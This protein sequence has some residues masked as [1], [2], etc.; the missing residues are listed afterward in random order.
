MTVSSAKAHNQKVGAVHT[1][2]HLHIGYRDFCHLFG[3]QAAHQVMIFGVGRDSPRITVFFQTAQDVHITLLSG[4][5]P[6]THS[7]LRITFIR[8]IA[9]FHF[10]SHI[11]RID[12][13]IARQ[14]RQPPCT[15][16]IG[17]KPIR[18]QNN[19]SHVLQRHLTSIIGSIKTMSGRSCSNH[20]HGR[21][22]VTSEQCLQQVCLLRFGGQTGRRTATLNI[23]HHQ[24]QFGDYSQVHRF[25][26]QTDTG[27]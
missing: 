14:V 26:F 4:T 25:R 13:R 3:T 16:T 9:I 22:A 6:I 23:N 12:G 7:G 8:S 5:S 17:N 18:Q 15:R 2:L 21:F 19:R 20:R 10:G 27:A 1:A 11:R 24:R